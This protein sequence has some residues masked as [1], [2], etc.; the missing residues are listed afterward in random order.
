MIQ[1]FTLSNFKYFI[2]FIFAFIIKDLFAQTPQH[3]KQS[4]GTANTI[5]FGS[6]TSNKAQWVY[7][8]SNFPTAINRGKI[9]KIYFRTSATTTSPFVYTN[10]NVKMG[11]TTITSFT[12]GP[13]ETGLQTCLSAATYTIQPTGAGNWVEIVLTNPFIYDPTKNFIVEVSQS[14]YSTGFS[15]YQGADPGNRRLYGLASNATG[16]AGAGGLADFGFTLS[17]L[18]TNDAG[19][20]KIDSPITFCT[21]AT[22]N[23][24]ATIKNMGINQ[25]NSVNV[26]WSVNGVLRTPIAY[27]TLLD[28]I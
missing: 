23:I 18:S 10:L 3:F 21:G 1:K 7:Y 13:Y 25:I 9:T 20:Q 2:A 24:Y 19:V 4:T 22:K 11:Y 26:N 6:T 28:T 5:P 14:S 17:P 27:T 8:P 12:T 16:T 15:L